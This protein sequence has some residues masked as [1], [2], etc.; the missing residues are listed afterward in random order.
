M[1][2]IDAE[3]LERKEFYGNEYCF[4]YVDAEDIDNA[5]TVDAV[6][7]ERLF[8]AQI[9]Q[10]ATDAFDAFDD[11]LQDALTIDAAP[12]VH[13][14]WAETDWVEMESGGH[15]LIKTPKAAL[16]CS[17][18]R[19]CFKKELLWKTNFCPNCGA[20]MDGGEDAEG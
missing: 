13:G 2:L 20:K 17:N 4:D 18:C 8:N 5:P 14:R 12:V 1:R 6:E 3:K 11:A 9:E 15:E 19:N 10:G 7:L 16:R